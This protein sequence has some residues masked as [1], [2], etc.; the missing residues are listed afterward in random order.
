ML[1]SARIVSA[2]RQYDNLRLTGQ[3]AV[4][5]GEYRKIRVRMR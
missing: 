1:V 2:Q 5:D 3:S 4:N